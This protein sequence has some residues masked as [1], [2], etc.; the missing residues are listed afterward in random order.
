[1]TTD[2]LPGGYWR[3]SQNMG[4]SRGSRGKVRLPDKRV[5]LDLSVPDRDERWLR[6]AR[7]CRTPVE[8][9]NRPP[10]PPQT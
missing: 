9:Q 3:I 4:K 7:R 8:G 10:E 5:V 2:V 1:M 6:T